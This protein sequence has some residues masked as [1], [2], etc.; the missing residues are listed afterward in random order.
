MSTDWQP[1]DT[2]P[3]CVPSSHEDGNGRKP[4]IV[5][6]FPFTGR[7]APMAIARLTRE[8]WIIGKVGA[9]RRYKKDNYL[10]FTP[11]HWIPLP[12]A[13]TAQPA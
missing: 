13:P 5:T 11:T 10:W 7:F 3:K 12:L 9:R 2:A 8:G 6:R 4:V 1:I